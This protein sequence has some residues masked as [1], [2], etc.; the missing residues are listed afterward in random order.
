ML[1]KVEKLYANGKNIVNLNPGQAREVLIEALNTVKSH[2]GI[3]K[4]KKADFSEI[5]AIVGNLLCELNDYKNGYTALNMAINLNPKNIDA[6]IYYAKA[7]KNR[8]NYDLALSTV[9]KAI[10]M[11]RKSKGAWETK[12]EIYEAMGDVDEALKIYLNLIN[13][14]PDELKY[15]EKYLK[16]K[17]NDEKILLKKGI[18]LYDKG[19]FDSSASTLQTVV[20]INPNNKEAYLYLG[21]A[22]EK[23]EKYEE[24]KE[25]ANR[26][27]EELSGL[28][29]QLKGSG[30]EVPEIES[31]E[32]NYLRRKL[33]EIDRSIKTLKI[34]AKE[35][36]AL[37]SRWKELA[38]VRSKAGLSVGEMPKRYEELKRVVGKW[39]NE[40]PSTEVAVEFIGDVVANEWSKGEIEIKNTGEINVES[41]EVEVSSDVVDVRG[42]RNVNLLK[43]GEA[44]KI[45]IRIKSKDAGYVPVELKVKWKNP[46]TGREEEKTIFPEI[47]VKK[48]I[49]EGAAVA[50][51]AVSHIP[52]GEI[53]K[54]YGIEE[55]E[56]YSWGEFSAYKMG[57][58]L[59]SGGFSVVYEVT[60][61]RRKYA[62]K[63][64]KG[65]DLNLG[66]TLLLREKDLE[67]Y[68]KEALIWAMLTEKVPDGAINL[69]DA[70]VHPFPWFVMEKAEKSLKETANMLSYEEKIKIIISLL[71][72]LE[73]IHRLDVVHRDIKPENILYANGKWKFTD[74]GLS[75]VLRNSSKSSMALS[76]TLLYMAPEQLSKKLYG[77][78]D[79]RTDIWQ[80]GVLI[81]ELFTGHLPFEEEDIGMV[82]ASI[83][84]EDP[85]PATEY[86]VDEKIW[87]VI[88]KA[89]RKKKEDRW[90]SAREIKRALKE[91]A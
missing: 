21:A 79:R 73:K 82:T 39:E 25:K 35:Y 9:D 42:L 31:M 14:Y 63:I 7:L 11:N 37:K 18:L 51:A 68:G 47:Y 2:I 66:E 40:R 89:L 20:N 56:E 77:H 83:L 54:M 10:A 86:G 27:K 67:Q 26:Q 46:L 78:T 65:I 34:K 55:K 64:P 58:I 57:K 48:E 84:N 85:M 59:G 45:P 38:D 23:I 50:G 88:E 17:P 41:V 74:F 53:K 76:G 16:Y 29:L 62:M 13:L 44:K 91:V 22:Y 1:K 30:I 36:E 52:V 81:Y 24:L 3:I 80:M 72:T 4:N 70:G 69:I 5:L 12:A 43:K 61:G 71:D 8:K 19:N 90:Q 60:K 75:K 6:L 32:L 87:K 49:S 15:Y 28:R 33:P